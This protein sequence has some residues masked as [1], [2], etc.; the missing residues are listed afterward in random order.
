MEPLTSIFKF[1]LNHIHIHRWRL[2]STLKMTI[3]RK[4]KN[5][6][7]T[8]KPNAGDGIGEQLQVFVFVLA[9][10]IVFVFMRGNVFVLLR[11][12]VN[13]DPVRGQCQMFPANI[14]RYFAFFISHVNIAMDTWVAVRL[15]SGVILI[16]TN[17]YVV[18]LLM[19]SWFS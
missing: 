19:P 7:L 3:A 12:I 2:F 15:G 18:V 8:M 9:K 14:R 11:G 4:G 16:A 13:G 17:M 5:F 1:K 6:S 10:G